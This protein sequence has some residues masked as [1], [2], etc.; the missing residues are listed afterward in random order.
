MPYIDPTDGN[1]GNYVDN[2][3]YFDVCYETHISD[4]HVNNYIDNWQKKT[5]VGVKLPTDA[6]C[7]S[8]LYLTGRAGSNY[9]IF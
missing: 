1:K 6:H 9:S 4:G 5:V 3:V 2:K 7:V 8:V